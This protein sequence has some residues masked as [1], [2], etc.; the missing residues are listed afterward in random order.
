M[1]RNGQAVLHCRFGP[2]RFLSHCHNGTE[3]GAPLPPAR[4]STAVTS[5]DRRG[6]EEEGNDDE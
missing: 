4:W 3:P 5:R 1:R 6:V 2:A